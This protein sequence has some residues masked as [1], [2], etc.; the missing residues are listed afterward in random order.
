MRTLVPHPVSTKGEGLYTRSLVPQRHRFFMSRM[1]IIKKAPIH[2]PH[3]DVVKISKI[4]L[5][6]EL[7]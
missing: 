3:R 2:T 1:K 5:V 7:Y 6:K 4:M